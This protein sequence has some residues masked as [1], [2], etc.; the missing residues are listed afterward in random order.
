[1]FMYNTVDNISVCT[2]QNGPQCLFVYNISV[3]TYIIYLT[4]F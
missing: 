4:D 3:D 1:M 2:V